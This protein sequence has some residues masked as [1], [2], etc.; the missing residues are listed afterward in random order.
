MG[1][2]EVIRLSI[3]KRLCRFWTLWLLGFGAAVGLTAGARAS[4]Y[5]PGD[6]TVARALQTADPA[7]IDDL[8]AVANA[9]GGGLPALVLPAL[10]AAVFLLIHRTRPLV[11]VL[12]L[13][14]LRPASSVLKWLTDRPRPAPDLVEVV[15]H[16]DG[17]TSFPSGHVLSSVLV[18]GGLAFAVQ[19]LQIPWL[20]RRAIQ[21][22]CLAVVMLV[23][24]AR[25][26]VGA[27]WPS[28]VLGGYLWGILLL[29]ALLR[30]LGSRGLGVPAAR[31]EGCGS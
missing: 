10:V 1:V 20:P 5:L 11:I 6:V 29:V 15:G 16:Y 26:D 3:A 14:A 12:G 9:V 27:H 7:A 22:A 24:P 31:V 30:V 17:A 8:F 13:N 4:P 23:G 25:V 18:F 28:D 19:E 21:A 2:Y